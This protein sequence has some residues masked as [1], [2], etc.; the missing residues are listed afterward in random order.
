M[1][2]QEK[3]HDRLAK[4]GVIGLG[5]VGLPLAVEFGKKFRT[6][7]FDVDQLRIEELKRG[8]D[9]TM[10]CTTEQLATSS[11]LDY[12]TDL[13]ILRS[14]DVYIVT[15]PTP[16]DENKSPDLRPL[17]G[18]SKTVGKVLECGNLVIYES[19]VYP[20]C[21]EEDCVPVLEKES[22]LTFNEDFFCGYSPERIN[23]GDKEHTV[24]KILKVTSGSTFEM[25]QVVDALYRAVVTAGTHLAPSIKV[26]EAAKVIEN[27]QRDINIAFVNELSM[28]F[29]RMGIDTNAV[30]EA[31]GTKWNFLPFRPGLVGGHCIGVDPYYLTQRAKQFGYHP[32]IIL[33]GRRL[34]DNM[35]KE[36][37]ER[38][39]KLMIH[40][41]LSI[42]NS[43]VLILGITFKENCPD[44]RNTRVIDV[45]REL[46]DFGCSVDVHDPWADDQEVIAEY[47]INLVSGNLDGEFLKYDSIVVA[48]AHDEFR[49]LNL[50][51]SYK[52]GCVI[53]DLKGI[54]SEDIIDGIL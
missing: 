23:P 41:G 30:L 51:K 36:V 33:A 14:C 42:K 18:A 31:A 49:K 43:S 16:I 2:L 38:V 4:I 52:Q 46:E 11:K 50:K 35:G 53:F 13:K 17:I 39:V 24:T 25:G 1:S 9:R 47:G 22:G 20:G 26:A 48:V 3:I 40:R 27:S 54:L 34:N 28:I 29:H 15:V 5:Y 19:T 32:E 10:E 37:A 45:I 6:I 8:Y 21:T 12:S 7:G 44:T